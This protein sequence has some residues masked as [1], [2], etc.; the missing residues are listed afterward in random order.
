MILFCTGVDQPLG[1]IA[2]TSVNAVDNAHNIVRQS[3][4][5]DASVKRLSR[6]SSGSANGTI[7]TLLLYVS[8]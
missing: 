5:S 4:S 2:K 8:K 7:L 3:T 6:K 1:A